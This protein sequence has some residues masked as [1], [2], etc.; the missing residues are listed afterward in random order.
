MLIADKRTQN[1]D[2]ERKTALNW[3][4]E[5]KEEKGETKQAS[6]CNPGREIEKEKQNKTQH[7]E[8]APSQARRLAEAGEECWS[9]RG[10]HSNQCRAA[11]I[12]MFLYK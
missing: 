8:K 7:S 12:E 4:G 2:R 11:K 5:K 3:S 10:K 1:S 9:I 6:T